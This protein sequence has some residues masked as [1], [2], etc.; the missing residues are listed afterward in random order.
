[1]K[2]LLKILL[3]IGLPVFLLGLLFKLQHYPFQQELILIG[4]AFLFFY[5]ML[6]FLVK[7]KSHDKWLL[8]LVDAI[9]ILIVILFSSKV[10]FMVFRIVNYNHIEDNVLIGLVALMIII[11]MIIVVRYS[12]HRRYRIFWLIILFIYSISGILVSLFHT[13]HHELDLNIIQGIN[14]DITLKNDSIRTA[15]DNVYNS[16]D[17]TNVNYE[18][19]K[20]IR[21]ANDSLNMMISTI[22]GEIVLYEDP[23]SILNKL[24]YA[25]LLKKR[26]VEYRE[27]CLMI[28]ASEE[29]NEKIKSN[30]YTDSIKTSDG[31][32]SWEEGNFSEL[33]IAVVLT[34]LTS[35]EKGVLNSESIALDYLRKPTLR[36]E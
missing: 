25:T 16:I 5:G 35:I 9:G 1:M 34:I 8:K 7:Y 12:E 11:L 26:I 18:H 23:D 33:P 24:G 27:L 6:F 10:I 28:D 3:S 31:Y 4:I 13:E 22:K 36:A 20:E 17:S 14:N 30:L 21:S 19:A 29:I 2:R 15:I 32:V